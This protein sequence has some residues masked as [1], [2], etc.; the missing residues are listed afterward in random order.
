MSDTVGEWNEHVHYR[1]TLENLAKTSYHDLLIVLQV[2]RV[3]CQG[4]KDWFCTY[5][6]WRPL[7]SASAA[8][9]LHFSRSFT[10][11]TN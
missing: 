10:I 8:K 3:W 2:M 11:P 1:D 4:S 9:G 7:R 5:P 6:V